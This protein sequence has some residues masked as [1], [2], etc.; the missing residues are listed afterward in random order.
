MD[1]CNFPI[2]EACNPELPNS[3]HLHWEMEGDKKK[4]EAH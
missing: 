3:T 4:T 1:G 2:C